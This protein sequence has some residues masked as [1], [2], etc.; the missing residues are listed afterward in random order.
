MSDLSQLVENS[1]EQGE[2]VSLDEPTIMPGTNNRKRSPAKMLPPAPPHRSA[3]CSKKN[4]TKFEKSVSQLQKIAELTSVDL[5]DEHDKFAHFVAAQ[6]RKMPPR[7]VI[8]LQ[9]KIQGLITAERLRLLDSVSPPS[10]TSSLVIPWSS[11][12][13]SGA[14]SSIHDDEDS[15]NANQNSADILSSFL[16]FDN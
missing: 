6:L 10:S 13:V 4:S 8:L 7:S 9:E 12:S 15:L 16:N 14:S 11:P 1:E 2:P 3:K 5:E